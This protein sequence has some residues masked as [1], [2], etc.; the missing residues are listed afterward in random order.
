MLRFPTKLQQRVIAIPVPDDIHFPLKVERGR[1]RSESGR[2]SWPRAA[3]QC[4]SVLPSC[5]LH[6]GHYIQLALDS[7]QHKRQLKSNRLS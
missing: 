1:Q 7:V 5:C 3:R 2:E 6:N 4:C